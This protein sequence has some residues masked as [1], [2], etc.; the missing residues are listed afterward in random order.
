MKHAAGVK[1]T[2]KW[3]LQYNHALT[4]GVDDQIHRI[5]GFG[6][7][8]LFRLLKGYSHLHVDAFFSFLPERI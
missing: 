5:V 6:N 4:E 1:V 2:N 3:F 7:H 8:V